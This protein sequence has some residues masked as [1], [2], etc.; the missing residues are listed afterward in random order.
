MTNGILNIKFQPKNIITFGND[1]NDGDGGRGGVGDGAGA[2]DRGCMWKLCY[3]L[4]L[5]P[6][7]MVL[8]STLLFFEWTRN[9]IFPKLNWPNVLIN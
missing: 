8:F 1:D 9:K 2:G 5:G 4:G 6:E 7:S 3:Y